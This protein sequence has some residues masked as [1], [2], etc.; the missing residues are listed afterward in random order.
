MCASMN[1][2]NNMRQSQTERSGAESVRYGVNVAATHT[3]REAYRLPI[4][5]AR[6]T[7]LDTIKQ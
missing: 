2:Y 1:E 4:N 7:L 3:I 6:S 5:V